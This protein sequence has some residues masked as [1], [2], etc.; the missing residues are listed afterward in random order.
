MVLVIKN[1][2]AN[3]GGAG[4]MGLILESGRFPGG[5]HGNPLQYSCLKNGMDRGAWQA[6]VHMVA[7]CQTQLKQ[8]SMHEDV[9]TYHGVR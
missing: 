1:P 3:A 6:A 4:D 7:R 9:R 8:L 2:A 5:E